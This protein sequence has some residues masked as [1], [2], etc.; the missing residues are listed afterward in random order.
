MKGRT[1]LALI[2]LF[3]LAVLA[4]GQTTPT[5]VTIIHTANIYGN[6]LP[7]NYFT[8][9]YEPKGLVQIYSYVNK[10]RSSGR[11]LLLVDTGNLLYGSPFGDY[12]LENP[13]TDNPV[14]AVF[15]KVDYDVFVPGTLEL[16]L[17][18]VKLSHLKLLKTNVVAINMA[19]NLSFVKPYYVKTFQSGLKVVLIGVV[20]LYEKVDYIN[21]LR[22]T[23]QK[24]KTEV[25]PD[26]IILA[27]SG[28]ITYDPI[29][30]KQ[31]SLASKFNLGDTLVKQF[32]NE[33]DVFLFGN[34]A[35]V[36]TGVNKQGKVFSLPGGDGAS[37]NQIDITLTRSDKKWK[38]SK[39]FI[40]NVKMESVSP[41]ME[42]LSLMQGYEAY[43]ERWL[44]T[45]VLRSEITVGFNKY[46]AI[47]ED[48][49]VTEIVNKAVIE[50]TK[51]QAGI[52]NIFN[53]NYE[54]FVKG[55][56][57]RR[58]IYQ[59]VGKTT[60]VKVLKLTGK[61]VKDII[62]KSL[63]MV[64]FDGSK[65]LFSSTL[66]NSPWLYDL[67][68]NIYY[69]VWLN[70]REIKKIEFAG[71]PLE[72]RDTLVV[73]VP[74]IRTYGQNPITS[75]TIISEIEIP[76]QRIVFDIVKSV[77]GGDILEHREDNNRTSEILLTYTVKPGDTLAQ[78][79][80]RLGLAKSKEDLPV[81]IAELMA[82]NPNIKDPNRIRPGWVFY[83]S[84][85]YLNLIPPL[86]ELFEIKKPG[87]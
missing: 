79:A 85:N 17:G 64:S 57:T 2:G 4:L 74:S 49:L 45:P 67:F 71:K 16:N 81:A 31:I 66:I 56:I 78:I 14:V 12:F 63:E 86:K 10:I 41:D 1:T 33:V 65:V 5:T 18:S 70:N 43:V 53:P 30:G 50:F 51:S 13:S 44:R 82:L 83:Y 37:V 35:M 32:S 87:H 39:V 3:V 23:L 40:Q 52:W 58:D 75:G 21:A 8:N 55:D 29:S 28:G 19:Q 7:F 61:E 69:S 84:K 42:L 48:S 38:V 62:K 72:D 22:S 80:Y 54:G 36:Y 47:L 76:V 59:L 6:V 68:E 20:P 25:A 60:T 27:T 77:I 11:E 73:S 9:T 26:L 24:V 34:Q 46:M 15:N